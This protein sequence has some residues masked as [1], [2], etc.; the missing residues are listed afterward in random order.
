VPASSPRSTLPHFNSSAMSGGSV[1]TPT[2][3]L[4]FIRRRLGVSLDT[5]M[6]EVGKLGPNSADSCAPGPKSSVGGVVKPESPNELPILGDMMHV[7]EG[8]ALGSM[9]KT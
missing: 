1:S 9:L 3:S 4:T 7:F 2:C 8:D 6:G 5:A